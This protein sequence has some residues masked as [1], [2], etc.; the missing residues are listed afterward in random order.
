MNE[1][2]GGVLLSPAFNKNPSP[3]RTVENAT[4]APRVLVEWMMADGVDARLSLQIHMFIWEP[5]KK[6]V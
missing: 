2:A 1:L 5:L 3:L 6:G 4:L